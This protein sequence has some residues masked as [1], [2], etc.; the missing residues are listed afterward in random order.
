VIKATSRIT[1][2]IVIEA[3]HARALRFIYSRVITQ[4]LRHSQKCD[5]GMPVIGAA[6]R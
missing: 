6:L 2:M 3:A 5:Y 4:I 1:V